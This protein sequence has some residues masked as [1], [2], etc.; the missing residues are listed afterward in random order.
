LE[1]LN[2]RVAWPFSAE[3]PHENIY[4]AE[5]MPVASKIGV[6]QPTPRLRQRTGEPP[7]DILNFSGAS[8]NDAASSPRIW[9]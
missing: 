6:E 8:Q 1:L 7:E 5:K 2:D 3:L 4:Q 9:K